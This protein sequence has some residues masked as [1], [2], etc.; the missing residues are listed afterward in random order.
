[1]DNQSSHRA[2]TY[3]QILQVQ[4]RAHTTMEKHIHTKH[5]R[6]LTYKAI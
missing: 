4:T 2:K 5:T 6:Q 3:I 1:M